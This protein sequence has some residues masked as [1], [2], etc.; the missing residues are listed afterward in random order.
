MQLQSCGSTIHAKTEGF[1]KLDYKTVYI[2]NEKICTWTIIANN[3]GESNF[4]TDLF[5]L[6][7]I[8]YIIFLSDQKISLTFTYLKFFESILTKTNS[9]CS[10]MKISVSKINKSKKSNIENF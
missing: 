9:S 10:A 5:L 7:E 8:F 1:I 6:N 3:P 4:H 2:P